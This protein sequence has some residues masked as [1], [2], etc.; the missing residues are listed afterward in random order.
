MHTQNLEDYSTKLE[1]RC[2]YRTENHLID[3]D[4]VQSHLLQV[5]TMDP[6]QQTP[7]LPSTA[8]Y[9]SIFIE[10]R[11]CVK[12]RSGR[13]Q[14]FIPLSGNSLAGFLLYLMGYWALSVGSCKG[15]VDTASFPLCHLIVDQRHACI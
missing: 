8:S 4:V 11:D 10:R 13:S 7:I 2:K 1:T 15:I 3:T 14:H 6:I 5:G 12:D 9:T